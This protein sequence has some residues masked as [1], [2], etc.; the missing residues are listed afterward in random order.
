MKTEQILPLLRVGAWIVYVGAIVQSVMI[1]VSFVL[2]RLK[3]ENDFQSHH[4]WSALGIVSLLWAISIL[5]V[6]VWEKVKDI[7]TEINLK[8]PFTMLTAHRLISTGHL[9]LSIWIVSFIGKNYMHFPQQSLTGTN[10]F[11][12]SFDFAMNGFDA[13][14]VYLLNAGIIYIIGQIFKRGVELQQEN[15]LMI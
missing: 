11:I 6:Q 4:F 7:L 3:G 15:E 1:P 14:V 8:N 12:E 13:D 9:L 5:H 10:E 2:S